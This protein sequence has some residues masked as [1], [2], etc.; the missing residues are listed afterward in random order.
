MSRDAPLAQFTFPDSPWGFSTIHWANEPGLAMIA[1]MARAST[2]PVGSVGRVQT[3]YLDLPHPGRLDC[4]RELHP[5]PVAYD[6]YRAL[7]PGRDNGILARHALS[8]AP[9]TAGLS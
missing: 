7:S 3:Q 9:H 8:A 1:L 5:T 4:G 6:A 2:L